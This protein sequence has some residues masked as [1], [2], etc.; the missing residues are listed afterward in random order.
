MRDRIGWLP[1]Q[2]AWLPRARWLAWLP[3]LLDVLLRG[4]AAPVLKWLQLQGAGESWHGLNPI[5]FCNGFFVA[6]LSV[7]LPT[8]WPG[9]QRLPRDLG[10]LAGR[11]RC[12]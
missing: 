9:R 2:P 4:L 5:S 8:L 7:G 10:S 1:P 3:L 6:Q 11:D 12:L